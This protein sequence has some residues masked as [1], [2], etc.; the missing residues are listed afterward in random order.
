MADYTSTWMLS[1]VSV[2]HDDQ[3]RVL[4]LRGGPAEVLRRIPRGRDPG[5]VL[6]APKPETA[7]GWRAK[8]PPDFEFTLKAWQLIT[9][10]A[11]SPTYRRLTEK[12]SPAQLRRC[13][14]FKPTDEV[15]RAWE[16]TDEIARALRSRII[17]FLPGDLHADRRTQG[18]PEK[19]LQTDPPPRLS[20]SLGAA[21]GVDARG[22]PE[23][24]RGAGPHPLCGPVQERRE[25]GNDQLLPDSRHHR[26]LASV[27]RRRSRNAEDTGREPARRVLPVQQRVH[28][29]RRAAVHQGKRTALT[30]VTDCC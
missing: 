8:A 29:G 22:G 11:S 5:H 10:E 19:L 13:G 12:L 23:P 18:E 14:S 2:R 24:L 6:P 27:H 28:A 3:S 26:P 20:P 7:L 17:A 16:R 9:H 30:P 21:R 15:F 1:Q 4:R 25:P